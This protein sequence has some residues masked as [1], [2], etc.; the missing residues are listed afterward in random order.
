MKFNFFPYYGDEEH[1]ENLFEI[2][3]R[4]K[5][6]FLNFQQKEIDLN[7]NLL[8]LR[9]LHFPIS[10]KFT[11]Y[12]PVYLLDDND[13][14]NNRMAKS[15]LTF[16][17]FSYYKRFSNKR[18]PYRINS[19]SDFIKNRP[20][21][22]A[23]GFFGQFHPRKNDNLLFC[24]T[25]EWYLQEVYPGL[26]TDIGPT[27]E[28]YNYN[29]ANINSYYYPFYKFHYKSSPSLTTFLTTKS[30]KEI[31]NLVKNN[32]LDFLNIKNIPYS[33]KSFVPPPDTS[34]N[35]FNEHMTFHQNLV[36]NEKVCKD[37][38]SRVNP[39]YCETMT[40]GGDQDKC[41]KN[42]ASILLLCPDTCNWCDDQNNFCE[43]L[44]LQKCNFLF[45]FFF[46]PFS[47]LS[48][49]FLFFPFFVF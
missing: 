30:N 49:F 28:A 6:S 33:P 16:S 39:D 24:T 32:E 34:I 45:S 25:F 19:P 10:S 22:S 11:Q 43:D 9:Y 38:N 37:I 29:I 23:F 40:N 15:G 35:K 21:E 42:K 8:A 46:S 3:Q 20:P 5:N 2:H 18:I 48:F 14:I 1:P 47:S 27:A 36:R 17:E 12:L 31:I 41:A 26:L 13:L 7:I 4:E 44:Y